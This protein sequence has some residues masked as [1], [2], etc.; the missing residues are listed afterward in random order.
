MEVGELSK[1]GLKTWRKV[2]LVE[3]RGVKVAEESG[4]GDGMERVQWQK[5]SHRSRR[6]QVVFPLGTRPIFLRLSCNFARIML[7]QNSKYKRKL[8]NCTMLQSTDIIKW[9]ENKEKGAIRKIN[10]KYRFQRERV[11]TLNII[12]RW[13]SSIIRAY[14]LRGPLTQRRRDSVYLRIRNNRT[15]NIQDP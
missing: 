8:A 7:L 14:S 2:V 10:M 5:C 6:V 3:E 9:S 4:N 12:S 11:Q 15:K 13:K 1:L